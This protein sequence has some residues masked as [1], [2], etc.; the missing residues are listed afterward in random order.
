MEPAVNPPYSD[1]QTRNL[2]LQ[3]MEYS[4][5]SQDREGLRRD[6]L[7][8]SLERLADVRG[9]AGKTDSGDIGDKIKELLEKKGKAFLHT[10]E[11]Y[12]AI[13]DQH[14]RMRAYRSLA[15]SSAV[16][17]GEDAEIAKNPFKYLGLPKDATFGQ[18]R[19]AWIR[20]GK[21][22]FPDLMVPEN[23]EQ[24]SRI[25][26]TEKFIIGGTD[27]A[28]WL[29]KILKS[30]PPQVLS[31]SD[32]EKLTAP[33]QEAYMQGREA[34]R[35]KEAEYEGVKAEMRLRA[36]QKMQIINKAYAEAKKRFSAEEGETFAGFSWETGV[37]R[38]GWMKRLM[39]MDG[40]EYNALSLEGDGQVRRD[41]GFWSHNGFAYLA[42]D[43]GD[44]YMADR[45]YRQEIYLRPFFAWTELV[46]GQELSPTL[47]D[48]MAGEYKLT[49]DKS[50]QLRLMIM[51]REKPEFVADALEIPTVKSEHY[52][53][54]NFLEEV[55]EGPRFYHTIGP[56]RQG[57]AFPLGI[58]FTPDGG[59]VLI[60]QSQKDQTGSWFAT[61]EAASF[62][63]ID[64]QMMMAIAYGPMLQSPKN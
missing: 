14:E 34:Y 10:A 13:E 40:P 59:M 63:P 22:W 6:Y 38:V 54:R 57:R 36:T 31:A 51:N 18:T 42:F 48:G 35:T 25:F 39:G 16:P 26:G 3:V 9:A 11:Y 43:F 55:Y 23:S 47:L 5:T 45:D 61:E 19:A 1:L 56:M 4:K 21:I 17:H 15:V 27:Y 64:V 33:E 49:H 46:R 12:A 60:Y 41:T 52:K 53:L 8:S 20:L 32:L 7:A 50:E 24:Y 29:E 44:C 28:S 2:V 30:V 58:E 37:H 62:T